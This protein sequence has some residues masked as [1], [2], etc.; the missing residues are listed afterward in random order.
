MASPPPRLNPDGDRFFEYQNS[1][2][3]CGR[4]ALNNLLQARYFIENDDHYRGITD[5]T[6]LQLATPIPL[7]SLCEYLRTKH[8]GYLEECQDTENYD[9]EILVAA[10][11][12][13]GRS[14]EQV[15]TMSSK[16]SKNLKP[17]AEVA[18]YIVNTRGNHYVALRKVAG[19]GGPR[20]ELI[21]SL[22]R[23]D[24][25]P[26]SRTSFGDLQEYIIANSSAIHDI[27]EV[28]EPTA[29]INPNV[30]IDAKKAT[31][32]ATEV[33]SRR[34]A[35]QI[36]TAKRNFIDFFETKYG[37]SLQ[38]D[39]GG[40]VLL[41]DYII[42]NVVANT[43]SVETLGTLRAILDTVE[44]ADL[45]AR[46]S[47]DH[48]PVVLSLVSPKEFIFFLKYE[49]ELTTQVNGT[50]LFRVILG[51][52]FKQEGLTTQDGDALYALFNVEAAEKAALVTL[53][54]AK[55]VTL[56]ACR[57]AADFIATVRSL[58]QG[59][60]IK[61]ARPTTP[62]K[63]TASSTTK[64]NLSP[65]SKSVL[66]NVVGNTFILD[67]GDTGNT[68]RKQYSDNKGG[69]L[70]EEELRLLKFLGVSDPA[71]KTIR[72][73]LHGFFGTLISC[74]TDAKVTMN[75]ECDM[76]M[77]F[78][79][80]LREMREEA[81]KNTM[82]GKKLITGFQLAT[83]RAMVDQAQRMLAFARVRGLLDCDGKKKGEEEGEGEEEEEGKKDPCI[84]ELFTV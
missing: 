43:D 67:I 83:L 30:K 76:P 17:V 18:G 54:N 8:E 6:I 84:E 48:L 35:R 33:D 81:A 38:N 13:I 80:Q 34:Y 82:R 46:L 70:D 32:T 72:P 60:P 36:E 69:N 26:T 65:G 75:K 22:R 56:E 50:P 53:L 68:R 24:E 52:F 12:A 40:G 11:E 61:V 63:I 23:R 58:Q 47:G 78:L 25:T 45:A 37:P 9:I 7:H 62:S 73:L 55:A 10:L 49:A 57:D 31:I 74:N 15:W 71:D 16:T 28:G 4:H 66:V 19:T 20:F 2:A 5:A 64:S 42:S 14:A 1:I 41:V 77:H 3:G 27:I 29:R 79:W 44:P 59:G 21:N 39:V 51:K